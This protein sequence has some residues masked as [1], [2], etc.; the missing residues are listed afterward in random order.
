MRKELDVKTDAGHTTQ[1]ITQNELR[2]LPRVKYSPV[3]FTLKANGG[4]KPQTY[5]PLDLEKP[6][7]DADLPHNEVYSAENRS[8]IGKGGYAEVWAAQ[9]KILQRKVAIKS[10]HKDLCDRFSAR[11]AFITE[12]RV[13]AYLDHPGI[14]PIYSLNGGDDRELSIA[15][16]LV[17]GKTLYEVLQLT[18]A[19][20]KRMKRRRVYREEQK[21]LYS[22]LEVFLKVCD[23]ISYAHHKHVLH[24]DLK[25][26]NIM[27]GDFN[28]VFVM[29]WGIAEHQSMNTLARVSGEISGTVTYLAPE[30][31]KRQPYDSRSDIY[32]L[33]AILFEIVYLKS[34]FDQEDDNEVCLAAINGRTSPR[35]HEF[36]CWVPRKL[37][38]IIDKAMAV[39]PEGRY[40]TVKMLS[41][42]L[43]T[44]LR[45]GDSLRESFLQTV[46]R[47]LYQLFR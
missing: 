31:I 34:A 32:S 25:P 12:A 20:Y 24:R 44:Y 37:R 13:T 7:H 46:R 35:R 29:D 18:K 28:E 33:G 2:A 6:F 26:S 3:T 30:I 23:A 19:D 11:S 9:D 4:L 45:G 40:A 43:R 10:L 41:D 39:D 21:N 15:M 1:I 16:K 5:Q 36:H 17:T 8:L 27:I 14:V 47:N 22:R 38:S 42:D